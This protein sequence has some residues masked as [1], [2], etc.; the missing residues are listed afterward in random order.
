MVV[1]TSNL[2]TNMVKALLFDVTV[3]LGLGGI[4]TASMLAHVFT[5]AFTAYTIRDIARDTT[6][7]TKLAGAIVVTAGAIAGGIKYE[8]KA[9][10]AI[11]GAF[12]NGAYE[13]A[14]FMQYNDD[15]AVVVIEGL[16]EM[17]SGINKAYH[18]NGTTSEYIVSGIN[19]G[20]FGGIPVGFS[21]VGIAA[22]AYEPVSKLAEFYLSP[23][24]VSTVALLALT[25]C[26]YIIGSKLGNM[27]LEY[28]NYYNNMA[29]DA[30]DHS[31]ALVNNTTNH[32]EL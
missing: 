7:G 19:G 3:T 10:K 27:T 9:G 29:T 20:L 31:L 12:N 8:T 4:K 21:I 24:V 5:G 2:S 22:L 25:D 14:K 32:S 23:V 1:T 6:A 13:F 11:F 18:N 28:Y 15:K 30:S 17:I 26:G 16:E